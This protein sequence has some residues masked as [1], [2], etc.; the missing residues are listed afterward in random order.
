M[1][2]ERNREATIEAIVSA[3]LPDMLSHVEVYWDFPS[4]C[5]KTHVVVKYMTL[6]ASYYKKRESIF[7]S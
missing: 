2:T 5:A 4:C 3:S 7:F 6:Y 1:S